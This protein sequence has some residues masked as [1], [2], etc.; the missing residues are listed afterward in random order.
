MSFDLCISRRDAIKVVTFGGIAIAGALGA[1]FFVNPAFGVDDGGGAGGGEG[2]SGEAGGP[3]AYRLGEGAA[4]RWFDR[5]GFYA[6]GDGPEGA[7]QGWDRDSAEWFWENQVKVWM[8]YLLGKEWGTKIEIQGDPD[9]SNHF[10]RTSALKKYYSAADDAIDAAKDVSGQKHA[11]VVGVGWYFQTRESD[12]AV[13]RLL[14][15]A[16]SENN[17]RKQTFDALLQKNAAPSAAR[18][19]PDL[20][21]ESIA[22]SHASEVAQIQG[23]TWNKINGINGRTGERRNWGGIGNSYKALSADAG[24]DLKVDVPGYEG[25]P[26]RDYIWQQGHDTLGSTEYVVVVVAAADG[27]PK[28]SGF[29]RISKR[30]SV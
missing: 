22:A 15:D 26:W 25:T 24:W 16:E 14:Y 3:S 20:P 2:G 30:M 5:G 6:D 11:R 4:W 12:P 27:W 21:T 17:S 9:Y 19:S 7:V 1:P 28:K 10:M 18:W 13:W 8:G 29:M 23:S